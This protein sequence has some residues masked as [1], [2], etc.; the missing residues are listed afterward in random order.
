MKLIFWLI[1]CV[2]TQQKAFFAS[3]T[4][5]IMLN[6]TPE[7]IVSMVCVF[8]P[9]YSIFTPIY[10]WCM[11]PGARLR[12][13]SHPRRPR[14]TGGALAPQPYSRTQWGQGAHHGRPLAFP[15]HPWFFCCGQYGPPRAAG[16]VRPRDGPCG[17][18]CDASD[19]A[20]RTPPHTAR[21][22][23]RIAHTPLM[24]TDAA[25]VS[26][27]CKPAHSDLEPPQRP[28]QPRPQPA[29]AQP[30]AAASARLILI[31][32]GAAY[33]PPAGLGKQDLVRQ[34]RPGRERSAVCGRTQLS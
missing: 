34:E 33:A 22:G 19:P 21:G 12:T 10:I 20:A 30:A 18:G 2:F 29:T 1:L 13:S 4:V 25:A 17:W 9:I 11:L 24:L 3:Y 15:R 16:R 31:G 5:Q 6:N 27:A 23:R 7:T 8:T 32:C 28:N 26:S 14:L